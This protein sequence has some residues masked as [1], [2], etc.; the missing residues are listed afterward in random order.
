MREH[1]VDGQPSASVDCGR[2]L[3][4]RFTGVTLMALI[5]GISTAAAGPGGDSVAVL[6]VDGETPRAG[7]AD[8]LRIQLRGLAE[9]DSSPRTFARAPLPAM[10]AE[11]AS[12]A[13]AAGHR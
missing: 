7:L 9:V 12:M 4:V 3:L 10:L 1:M 13:Q 8:E 2:T 6:V 5:V 11:A